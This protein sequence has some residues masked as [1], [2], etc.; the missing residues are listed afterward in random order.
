MRV[1]N[2]KTVLIATITGL[3]AIVLGVAGWATV[4]AIQLADARA[5]YE[6][7][8]AELDAAQQ[9]AT[10]LEDSL[11][12]A[13]EAHTADL[14]VAE[15]LVTLLGEGTDTLLAAA[16]GTHTSRDDADRF[17]TPDA[18]A[19]TAG[20][21][22]EN[23][24][25][26]DYTALRADL[27][28]LTARWVSYTDNLESEADTIT[29][30]NEALAALW[31]AQVDTAAN[32]AAN[33]ATAAI[34]TNPNAS[35]EAKDAATAAAD[36]LGALANPL[37]PE[38]IELWQALLNANN[39]LAAQEQAYQEQKAAEEEAARRAAANRAPSRGGSASG[40]G[41]SPGG[42]YPTVEDRLAELEASVALDAGVDASAVNCFQISNGIRCE[43][44]GGS[45]TFTF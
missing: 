40:G 30:D 9:A 2:P 4:T 14:D 15:Q 42:G 29:S 25:V 1:T 21:L 16:D 24:S 22:P 18:P 19:R 20:R 28:A 27:E 34:N 7:A 13:I 41:S 39:T 6:T 10:G 32:T 23:P 33:T 26:D 35:Q 31:Q 8:S 37:D 44:P 17:A 12:A 36:A 5:A 11:A 45:R 38:A 3:A 43:W